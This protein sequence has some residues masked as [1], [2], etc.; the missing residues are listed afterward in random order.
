MFS[1]I[2]DPSVR[3]A[4]LLSY[5]AASKKEREIER[6]VRYWEKNADV[7]V[8]GFTMDG[9]GRWDVPSGNMVCIDPDQWVT[10]RGS[11]ADGQSVPVR[12]LHAPNHRGAKGTEF[13]IES[14][15]ALKRE[16]L[17]VELL[18]AERLPNE[19]VRR[20]MQ[21]VDIL[22]DQLILPG[23]GLNAIEGMASGLPVIANLE[24]R[25]SVNVFRRYSFL[26]E[27]PIVSASPESFVHVLRALVMNS[28]LRKEI[29][30]AGRAYVEKYHS[31]TSAQYLFGSI[32][33]R[34][35]NGESID[36]NNLYH[37]LKSPYVR[38]QARVRHPLI[39]NQLPAEYT[40]RC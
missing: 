6:R 16:G 15:E 35:L 12:V 21:E 24:D 20:L 31:Y 8:M 39:E 9:T 29:G 17:A 26:G 2:A 38:D 11:D 22:A 33:K 30:Q 18:L 37:P 27:C 14:I 28:T 7:I 36:L 40:Q 32:Y 1:R 3:N 19:E 10:G 34:L 5:P 13:I 25:L 23:Y 4:M